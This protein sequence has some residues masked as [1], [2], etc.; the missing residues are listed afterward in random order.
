[1]NEQA[2]PDPQAGDRA[3][4][5]GDGSCVLQVVPALETGGGGAE[6]STI[7]VAAAL[8]ARGHRAVVASTGGQLVRELD[9]TG[10]RHLAMPVAAK[11]PFVM[12]ANVERICH[13]IDEFAVDLV[14]ARSR[15]PAWS[16]L[17]AAH[18]SGVPFVTTFH[19]TY[20]FKGPLKR[21][22]NSVMTRGDLVIANS[23][24]I[25]DHVV[26]NYQLAAER[27][28]IIPRGV[29]LE[30]FSPERV[31]PE[32]VIAL[33][34]QWN[35]RDDTLVVMLPARL[36]RWKG[37]VVLLEALA[38]LRPENAVCLLVGA[39]GG[40]DRYRREL[41]ARITRTGLSNIVHLTGH[42]RDMPAALMLA[43]VVV[44]A[45]TEPEAFGRVIAE[46]Q[47]MGCPVIVADH[48]GGAEQVRGSG[49]GWLFPPGDAAG[50]ASALEE[51]LRLGREERERISVLSTAHVKEHYTKE[52]MCAAT[53]DVYDE[54]LARH[55][56]PAA[57]AP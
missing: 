50:L 53:L 48:G 10:A 43:D 8:M 3:T 40:R 51:A 27:I 57:S 26:A 36:V 2:Q 34:R 52:R 14:H 7:D 24:F 12:R 30:L 49:V 41:E 9:R 23:R 45:S 19:G 4:R 21:W 16:A 29:D 1:M 6:R 54:V 44:S 15:A 13:A 5:S 47:A 17:A 46:A 35:V 56:G 28:R 55:R 32:R 33:S 39:E 31:S 37:H 11:N 18:R 38:R 42:C 25:A 20:T 22:Y